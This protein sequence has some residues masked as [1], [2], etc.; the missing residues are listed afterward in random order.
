MF[1]LYWFLLRREKLFVFNRFFLIFSII[2]SLIIP[3]IVIP[4][5]IQNKQLKNNVVTIL[6]GNIP[7]FNHTQNAIPI[8][9]NQPDT[10]IVGSVS[11]A[12]S[13]SAS[14]LTSTGRLTPAIDFLEILSILY[15]SVV[16]L[17]LV[18]FLKNIFIIRQNLKL[19]EK[20]VYS[21][22]RI[23]LLDYQINPFC[24][25]NTIFVNK[26]DYLNNKL[27]KELLAHELEHI[28]QSHSIDVIFVELVQIFFWFNPILVLYNRAVRE[29]HEYLADNGVVQYSLDALRYAHE[30]INFISYR[31]SNQLTCGFNASLIKKRIIMLMKPRSNMTSYCVRI[32]ALLI[33]VTVLFIILSCVLINSQS[34][35]SILQQKM[36]VDGIVNDEQG[37]PL[38]D[39]T[40]LS[41]GTL[42][43]SLFTSSGTDGRF[44]L[45]DVPSDAKLIFQ[46]KGYK[47][48]IIKPDLTKE[49]K[50]VMVRD[51]GIK[52]EEFKIIGYGDGSSATEPIKVVSAKDGTPIDALIVIDGIIT[53]KKNF[54]KIN[55][56]DI[57]SI[58]VIKDPSVTAVYGE[59]GE[60]GIILIT[61]KKVPYA[62]DGVII[63]S[64]D[65]VRRLHR[66]GIIASTTLLSPEK[67]VI[68]YGEA[69]K[70][71]LNE[72]MSYE[73]ADE[74][75]IKFP[76]RSYR[77]RNP[78]DYPT[79]MGGDASSY[80]KWIADHIK[81]PAEAVQKGISGHVTV[82]Y[83]VS[84]DGSVRQMIPYYSNSL[85][86]APLVKAMQSSP[87]WDPA[88]NPEARE[89]YYSEVIVR[90]EL[91]DKV[92]FDDTFSNVEH[93]PEYPGGLVA[94]DNYI[95]LNI[96]YP[97]AAKTE[98]IE[99]TVFVRFIVNIDGNV[100]EASVI[101]SV[102]P[103]LDAEAIRVVSTV[104]G[105]KAG[106]QGGKP[107]NVYY[108]LT[109][110]FSLPTSNPS[111]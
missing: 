98:K 47:R 101:K 63:E 105:W 107:V 64:R 7:A 22:Y 3:F 82:T 14:T 8:N 21:G 34:N 18:R 44:R 93:M 49:M 35:G 61:T 28:K 108:S 100:E 26:H 104:S 110:I 94:L 24:F 86:A 4:V 103:L 75:G 95:K 74:L 80:A 58:S 57:T 15:I 109:V 30:L 33:S 85:L 53:D 50:I 67:A 43:E 10:E 31:R 55:S 52:V 29:N 83:T 17:L 23:A 69:G 72:L 45:A 46:H 27:A 66:K 41:A 79:F 111:K 102:H 77:R 1:G 90:F 92:S 51:T 13:T 19:S 68:K 88:K 73:K 91:P 70:N 38:G 60:N 20:A 6:N 65:E 37:N 42:G 59:K 76:L 99:G 56:N 39:V 12:T 106:I 25:L 48:I 36:R 54:E 97:Q 2:F 32:S 81:Y 87:K 78:E 9:S 11:T 96:K 84:A 5:N 71:G 89:D 62:L 40:I 16:I